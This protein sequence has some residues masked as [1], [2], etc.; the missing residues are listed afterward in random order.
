[1]DL[2]FPG[3]SAIKNPPASTGDMGL[4]PGSGR[5]PGERNGNPLQH[6]CLGNPRQEEEEPG[7]L[8]SMG[9]QRGVQDL[10]TK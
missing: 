5:S 10:G 1:M 7:E 2:G 3:G 9:L 4:I 6:S 8:Q